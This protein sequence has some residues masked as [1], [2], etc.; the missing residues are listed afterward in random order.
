MTT[1]DDVI[2]DWQERA[3]VIEFGVPLGVPLPD[4]SRAAA[5][6]KAWARMIELYG[7]AIVDE[8]KRVARGGKHV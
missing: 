6:R 8:A 1:I 5:E 2:D 7:Q 4:R 3:A